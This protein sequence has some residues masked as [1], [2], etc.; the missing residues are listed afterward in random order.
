VNNRK[1]NIWKKAVVAYFMVLS[2]YPPGNFEDN[3]NLDS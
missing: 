2:M 3:L 1:V